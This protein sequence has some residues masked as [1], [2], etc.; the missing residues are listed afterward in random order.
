[1]TSFPVPYLRKGRGDIGFLLIIIVPL[2]LIL[3]IPAENGRIAVGEAGL[4]LTVRVLEFLPA[5]S[6]PSLG[7]STKAKV[8]HIGAVDYGPVA[9]SEVVGGSRGSV[10]DALMRE[11]HAH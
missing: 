1:M 4:P 10:Y 6:I 3:S 9:P 11:I 5:S 8:E 7:I 2:H